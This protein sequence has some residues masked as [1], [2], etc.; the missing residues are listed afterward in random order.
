MNDALPQVLV[1]ED[2]QDV[3]DAVGET[4]EDAGYAVS[5]AGNGALALDTLESS[6]GLPDLILLDLMMPV[7]DGERFL[8]HFKNEPRY[9][10]VPVVLLTADSN[11][12]HLAGKLG[13]HGALTKPVQLDELLSTVER[14]AK[15]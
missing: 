1:V 6:K 11:A 15:A 10:E 9:Q 2:D 4:L 3:R 14:F 12:R 5:T 8:E 13:V 7:M